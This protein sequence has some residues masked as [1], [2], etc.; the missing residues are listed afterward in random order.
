MKKETMTS[1][2]RVLS[3]IN[4]KPVDRVPIDLGMHPSTGISAFA[5]YNLRKYLGMPINE[6]EITDMVQFL[7]RVDEDILKRFHCDCV[8]VHPRFRKTEVWNPRGEYKFTIPATANPQKN[9]RGDWVVEYGWG[10]MRMPAGGYFFDGDWLDVDDRDE[11]EWVKDV[12]ANA[13]RIYKETDYFASVWGFGGFFSEG[14]IEWQC[15]MLTDP[16]EIIEEN[17]RALKN[18]TEKAGKV[19]KAGGGYIQGLCLGADLGTQQGPMVRP[20]VYEQ[21]V[22]PYLKAFCDFV[23]RNSDFKIF[24]HCC[25]SIK[26]MIPILIDCGIDVLNPVQISANNMEPSELKAE[27]GD[28]LTFWGGGCDTQ[29]VLGTASP[30]EVAENVAHLMGIFKQGSGFVFN[31]VHNIMGNVPPENIVA[32]L[33][34][35]YENAF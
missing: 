11:D 15:R 23:H 18:M 34:A 35:A 30:K 8:P 4:H 31:Q 14:D 12:A 24:Y 5:Y 9:E 28:K 33:D 27:F 29:N 26:P 17:E 3:A 6:I 21:L 16:D 20:S 25:G 1:R 10:K 2:E 22:A 13:E 7:P 19:I 32:M